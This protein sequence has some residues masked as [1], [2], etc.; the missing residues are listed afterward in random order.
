MRRVTTLLVLTN[1]PDQAA[2]RSLAEQL[3]AARLAACVNILAP[4]RSVYRWQGE[5]ETADE[6]PLLIKTSSERFAELA[7]AIR[8]S[9]PYE[10]PEV[11]ALEIAAGLPEYLAWVTAETAPS[12]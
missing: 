1:L 3:V 8:A 10:L 4:C 6:V 2:A 5:V 9:H 7:A 11:V 12:A